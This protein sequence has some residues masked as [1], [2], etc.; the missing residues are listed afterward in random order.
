LMDSSPPQSG[1][2]QSSPR[3]YRSRTAKRAVETRSNSQLNHGTWPTWLRHIVHRVLP[4]DTPTLVT[5]SRTS[6]S[7]GAQARAVLLRDVSLSRDPA[8]VVSFQRFV[9]ANKLGYHIRKLFICRG[10]FYSNPPFLGPRGYGDWDPAEPEVVASAVAEVLAEAPRLR[11][12]CIDKFAQDM[13]AMEPRLGKTLTSRNHLTD[14][15]LRDVGA[16]ALN[17]LS[18]LRGLRQLTLIRFTAAPTQV[19]NS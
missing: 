1:A 14:L 5:L 7:L 8:Q 4:A 16:D 12:L 15:T 18:D 3:R 2:F 17:S 6:K 13:L 19:N 10:A 9:V 11:V